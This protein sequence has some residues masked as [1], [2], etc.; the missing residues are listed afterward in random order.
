MSNSNYRLLIRTDEKLVDPDYV[1]DLMDL[2]VSPFVAKGSVA[3]AYCLGECI[4]AWGTLEEMERLQKAIATKGHQ[5]RIDFR[6]EPC[7]NGKSNLCDDD[8]GSGDETNAM[9]P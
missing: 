5:S 2:G 7:Q 3:V 6:D 1:K 4:L 9:F 8:P